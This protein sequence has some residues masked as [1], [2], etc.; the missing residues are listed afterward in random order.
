[1]TTIPLWTQRNEAEALSPADASKLD[2]L[3]DCLLPGDKQ[4]GIP[5]ASQLRA[6]RFVSRLLALDAEV[7][8]EIPEWRQ[9]YVTTIASLDQ[10]ALTRWGADLSNVA[11]ENI[12]ELLAE[13]QKGR[14]EGFPASPEQSVVFKTLLRHCYQACFGDPRWG[15]NSGA[16]G[17]EAIGYPLR[18]AERS[19]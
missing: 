3:M 4:S 2:R 9:L 8:C 6:A 12:D 16:R 15:G 14:L 19:E 5:S 10:I 18:I 13:L 17:W 11:A 1:M 7:Y